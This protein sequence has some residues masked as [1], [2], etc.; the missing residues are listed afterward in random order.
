MQLV[1]NG[2]DAAEIVLSDKVEPFSIGSNWRRKGRGSVHE[3]LPLSQ[4]GC[5]AFL[6][7]LSIGEVALQEK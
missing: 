4:G 5:A 2:G 1:I 6:I 3:K 7:G